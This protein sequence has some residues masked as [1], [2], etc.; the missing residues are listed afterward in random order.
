MDIFTNRQKLC[1][2][3]TKKFPFISR[4]FPVPGQAERID[5]LQKE[6]IRCVSSKNEKTFIDR[7]YGKSYY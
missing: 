2:N 3:Y 6:M 5:R 7:I 4:H 1:E